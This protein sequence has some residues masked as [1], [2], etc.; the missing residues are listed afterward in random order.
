MVLSSYDAQELTIIIAYF[1]LY[2]TDSVL[3]EDNVAFDTVGHCF[4]TEN[5]GEI[6]NTFK[7]N[8]GSKTRRQSAGIGASDRDCA[9]FWVT[10][11]RNH[12]IG[13]VAAGELE[14][15]I[16]FMISCMLQALT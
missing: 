3:V 5:G 11:P 13:N 6:D 8:L 16:I 4:I 12:F 14:V 7:N 1:L 2:R 9:T 15:M 10:S